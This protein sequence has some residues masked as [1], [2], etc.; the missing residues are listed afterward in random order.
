MTTQKNGVTIP[1]NGKKVETALTVVPKVDPVIKT[2]GDAPPLEDRILR[3]NQL[4]ELQSRYNR[5][6]NSQTKLNEFKM[7]KGEENISITI[8]DSHSR[9]EFETKNPEL[10]NSVLECVRVTVQ[11]KKKAIEPLLKW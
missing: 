7:K 3:I 11:E 1:T 5:L 10:I 4:F 2:A 9:E 6:Q 8:R